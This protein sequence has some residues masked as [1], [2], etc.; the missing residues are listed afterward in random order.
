MY[1]TNPT[2]SKEIALYLEKGD[3]VKCQSLLCS[4]L[5][6][7]YRSGL[8]K[9]LRCG[10]CTGNWVEPG[11]TIPAMSFTS[12]VECNC[13]FTL[14]REFKGNN[15]LCPRCRPLLK[16]NNDN[17]IDTKYKGTNKNPKKV[18]FDKKIPNNYFEHKQG[19]ESNNEPIYCK[20]CSKYK[21]NVSYDAIPCKPTEKV[22]M[23]G[24][25]RHVAGKLI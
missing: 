20:Y 24:D 18:H 19:A 1:R 13:Q 15:P 22:L 16:T 25:C 23:C 3:A 11:K 8:L 2:E 17:T 5:F 7:V 21:K 12:C 9:A 14:N 4:E 6:C 10:K